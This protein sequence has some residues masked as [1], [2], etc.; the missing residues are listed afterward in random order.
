MSVTTRTVS[1]LSVFL[2]YVDIDTDSRSV[3]YIAMIYHYRSGLKPKG[4]SARPPMRVE[5]MW[6]GVH[7]DKSTKSF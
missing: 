2:L 3:E 5:T 7:V 1:I 6:R 4:H